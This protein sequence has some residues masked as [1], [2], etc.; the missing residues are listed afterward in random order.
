MKAKHS[1]LRGSSLL[2]NRFNPYYGLFE[3]GAADNY[4]LQVKPSLFSTCKLQSV[5]NS[6]CLRL[7]FIANLISS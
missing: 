4:T 1:V 5:E 3:Y 2:V 7:F 6:N